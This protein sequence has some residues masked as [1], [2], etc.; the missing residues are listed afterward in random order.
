MTELTV[1]VPQRSACD[2][3]TP[4]NQTFTMMVSDQV[5]QDV[6]YLMSEENDADIQWDMVTQV[7]R[8]AA[9]FGT[10]E[11]ALLT[12]WTVINVEVEGGW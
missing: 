3:C 11:K 5:E 1:T 10:R 2:C 8:T 7:L 6:R 9:G 12:T 4:D